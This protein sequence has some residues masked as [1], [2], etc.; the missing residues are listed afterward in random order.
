MRNIIKLAALLAFAST[1]SNAFAEERASG[2][3]LITLGTLAGPFPS[4][5]RAQSS[6]LVVV[7]GVYYIFD[8]GDGVVRRLA[9][10]NIPL[11][12]IGLV[13]LTHLHDDHTAGLPALLGAAWDSKRTDPI[14]VYGPP[15]TEQLVKALIDFDKISA[16]IRIVDG[17]RSIP[18]ET[19]FSGHDTMPGVIYQDGN[20]KII[21][22]QNSHFD[23]HKTKNPDAH[24]G[25]YTYRVETRD[26]VIVFTGDTGPNPETERLAAGADIL[27]S[28]VN[29]VEDRKQI[30]IDTG[31]WATMT[32]EEKSRI[33]EQA[34][35]GHMSP[36]EVGE[37]AVKARVKSVVLTHL[38][39]R[40]H[41]DDYSSWAEEVG[42]VFKGTVMLANDLAEF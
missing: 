33:M 23:F 10:A 40:A 6:N 27:V 38:T 19:L 32:D 31:Q 24:E 36:A 34:A 12:N 16:D 28:E 3:K 25:S 1:S 9:E 15:K 2:T 17:G 18:I 29:S 8:A 13:F 21:A 26:K 4:K 14:N 35:R 11:Q 5:T 20:V 42:K 30:L 37:L 39:P 22:G 41:N 7:N